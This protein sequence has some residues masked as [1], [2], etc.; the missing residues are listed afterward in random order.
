MLARTRSGSCCQ[1]EGRSGCYWVLALGMRTS[2]HP[3]DRPWAKRWECH[4]NYGEC[5]SRRR[6]SI[7]RGGLR[8][9]PSRSP[10]TRASPPPFANCEFP[11]TQWS[12]GHTSTNTRA[13]DPPAIRPRTRWG[14][15]DRSGKR[16]DPYFS[17]RSRA[18]D[19]SALPG[20]RRVSVP[21]GHRH[22][23]RKMPRISREG[24]GRGSAEP[25]PG[26][27]LLDHDDQRSE[28][29]SRQA[30]QE[31]LSAGTELVQQISG[32]DAR[33]SHRS[34]TEFPSDTQIQDRRR[35]TLPGTPSSSTRAQRRARAGGPGTP[36]WTKEA[37]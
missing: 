1:R 37:P 17:L 36:G 6:I 16:V 13:R 2:E 4:P 34:F 23:N 5:G 21:R 9:R 30:P 29:T 14:R 12:C 19:P 27:P 24:D 18:D 28:G 11:C 7:T 35:P 26:P 20:N 3:A 22:D 15:P 25:A 10:D 8:Y 33:N 31:S 32:E